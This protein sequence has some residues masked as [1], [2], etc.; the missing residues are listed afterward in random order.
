LAGYPGVTDTTRRLL[1]YWFE[2]DHLLASGEPFRYY[3][4]QRE[5]V[6][7]VVYLFEVEGIGTA[8]T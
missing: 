7:T 1:T 2:D 4:C 8:R 5:A 6:E 3:F